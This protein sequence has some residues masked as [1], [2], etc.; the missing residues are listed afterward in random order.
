MHTSGLQGDALAVARLA[1]LQDLH[2]VTLDG[3]AVPRD[4]IG[5]VMAFMLIYG[6]VTVGLTMVLLASG[7]DVVTAF[8]AVIGCVN[9]IGPGMGQV[10]PAG[11][12]GALTDFQ[13]W[14]C[15]LAMLLGRLELLSVLVLL[16][17]QF[18]RR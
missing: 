12:F 10:G 1:C 5:A 16:T 15:S 11:N 6:G 8:T 9:N 17:P 2:P 3:A 18:W 13:I 14:V 7:M 4:V